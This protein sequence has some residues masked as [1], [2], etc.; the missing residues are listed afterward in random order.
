MI[1]FMHL[2]RTLITLYYGCV[3]NHKSQNPCV[4]YA[5]VFMLSATATLILHVHDY[6]AAISV[7]HVQLKSSSG[8]MFAYVFS[9]SA[10]RCFPAPLLGLMAC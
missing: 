10:K 7:G 8:F 4:K 3:I 6:P 1:E 5:Q 9:S 2:E